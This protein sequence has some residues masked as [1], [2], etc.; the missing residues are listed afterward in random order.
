MGFPGGVAW[1][2]M[3]AR[4]CQ[5]YP[6]V[7]AATMVGKFFRILAKWEWPAPILLKN[8]EDG[9][10]AVRVWN[11]KTYPADRAHRM[12]VITPAYP[13]M[14]ATHNVTQSTLRIII[15]ELNR[16][17]EFTDK[18][19]KEN[20][21]WDTLFEKNDFFHKYKYYLQVIASSDN[22]DSHRVWSSFVES[23]IRTLVLRLELVELLA[24]AHPFVKGFEKT[25]KCFSEQQAIDAGRGIFH[26]PQNGE[27][28][29]EESA[30]SNESLVDEKSTEDT[31]DGKIVHTTTFYVGLS[32]EKNQ[33]S[34]TGPKRLDISWPT[35]EFTK[36][37]KTWE[38]Y[39]ENSMGICVKYIKRWVFFNF[40][41]SSK[42]A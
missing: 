38:N 35:N 20:L 5:L 8:I 14:C 19:L 37:C 17:A 32:V 40:R 2:M 10:L 26:H 34:G 4:V 29:L 31:D 9:P 7:V 23:R 28:I 41:L 30:D 25:V 1:A 24:I 16:G 11:P 33:A 18:I 36:T 27:K 42:L 3:V 12:P 39:D 21:S 13:S 15:S 22:I 6:N